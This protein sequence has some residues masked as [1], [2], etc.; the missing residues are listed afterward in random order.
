[1]EKLFAKRLVHTIPSAHLNGLRNVC[2]DERKPVFRHGLDGTAP[3]Q[4]LDTGK[5][6]KAAVADAPE[7]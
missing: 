1:M 3:S 7:R 4:P 2:F 6:V 5:T